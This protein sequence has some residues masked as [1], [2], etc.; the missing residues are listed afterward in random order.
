MT[1]QARYSPPKLVRL[2]G[3]AAILDFG[4][5]RAHDD[6]TFPALVEIHFLR[7]LPNRVRSL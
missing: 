1:D 6:R 3:S 2:C 5:V 7:N 4:D